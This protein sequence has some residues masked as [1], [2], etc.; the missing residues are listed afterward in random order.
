MARKQKYFK[1][2]AQIFSRPR[3]RLNRI[4]SKSQ[5]LVKLQNAL[6]QTFPGE[7]Y[8]AS[9]SEGILHLITPSASL[10]T[11][12]RYRQKAIKAALEQMPLPGA[13]SHNRREVLQIMQIK[14]T[15][16]PN[17]KLPTAP[18]RSAIAPSPE[19]ARLIAEIAQYIEDEPL[20]KA[21]IRLSRRG[22]T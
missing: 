10:A 19:T 6:R 18:K 12:L 14:V 11:R 22:E 17:Y 20:R 5:D 1:D 15:V 21:L 2:P 13:G 8:V 3:S 7:V 4:F 16:S 9:L